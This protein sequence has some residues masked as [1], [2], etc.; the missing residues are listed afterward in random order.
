MTD[1]AMPLPVR[2]TLL[3]LWTLTFLCKGIPA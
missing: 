1:N 2:L 3:T